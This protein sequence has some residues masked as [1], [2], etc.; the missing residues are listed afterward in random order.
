MLLLIFLAGLGI[1][2][3]DRQ[4]IFGVGEHLL[5]DHHAQ[6]F[7]GQPARVLTVVLG[8]CAQ[9]E[10]DDLVAEILGIADA[11]R[12]FDLF[13]LLVQGHAVEDFAGVRIAVF[14]ILNPEIRVHHI[15]VENVLPVLAVGLQIRSL[16]F[17]ADEI[18]IARRQVFLDKAQVALAGVGRELLLLN[19][20]LQYI[21][22]VHRVGRHL[23]VVVVEHLGQNLEGKARRQTIHTFIYPGAVT[24]FLNRLG[25]G[26]GILEI[27]A[28]VDTHFRVEIRVVRLLQARQYRELGQHL[29]GI[30]GAV[31]VGQ[32]TA[33]QE[34]LIDLDFITD[35]QAIGHLDDVDAVNEG[36]VVLVVAEGVPL[37]LVGVCQDHAVEGYS[38]QPLGAVVVALLGRGE[39]RVQ[40]LDRCLEHLDK[41]HQPLVG[42]AQGTGIAVGVR[43]VLRKLLE[44]ANIDLADQRRNILIVLVAGLGFGNRR[45][46][47]DR[48]VELDHPELADVAIELMQALDCPG[49]HDAVDIAPGDA[50]IL[51][52]NRT[53]LF[54]T[55]QSER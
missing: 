54:R 17:L 22:Q 1:E 6:L 26:I 4:Q 29:Q 14:L 31:G 8:A 5:L 50:V 15:A 12:L 21:E 36:F 43:I 42:A 49:R 7:I 35:A 11:R 40:Y 32:G 13:Q 27:L 53:V 33:G 10:I 55:E 19:L 2:A 24:V 38:P 47:Q 3:D 16:D 41:F 52:E 23:G 39:Q 46:L 34:F 37:G 18:D 9:H 48:G 25:L 30:R 45:L 44:L 28:V 20:L 51:F